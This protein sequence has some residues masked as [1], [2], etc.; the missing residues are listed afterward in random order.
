VLHFVPGELWWMVA[1]GMSLHIAE[2]MCTGHGVTLLWPV[3][4]HRIGGDGR[5][6]AGSRA[7]AKRRP[8]GNRPSSQRPAGR[9]ATPGGPSTRPF[10]TGPWKPGRLGHAMDWVQ[11]CGECLD[12][13]HEWCTDRSCKCNRAGIEHPRRPGKPQAEP[14]P[15][16]PED[17]PF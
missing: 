1:L 4:R 10:R 9:P 8:A 7:P 16:L 15:P 13:S 11:Q 3:Y 14:R 5:Q 17:P 2:D 6:P 12:G